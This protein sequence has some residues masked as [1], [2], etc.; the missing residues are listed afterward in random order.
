[1]QIEA[2]LS[3]ISGFVPSSFN[4]VLVC[5]QGMDPYTEYDIHEY[6]IGQ[7]V[8][9]ATKVDEDNE[10]KVNYLSLWTL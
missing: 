1:M 7:I 6:W 2:S 8:E 9:F 4:S 3:L 5:S 10:D